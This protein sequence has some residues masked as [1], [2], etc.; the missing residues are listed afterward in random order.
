MTPLHNSSELRTVAGKQRG[1]LPMPT[2]SACVVDSTQS[3]VQNHLSR[4]IGKCR[5]AGTSQRTSVHAK[6]TAYCVLT[7]ECRNIAW[8]IHNGVDSRYASLAVPSYSEPARLF[9]WC[10]RTNR[11]TSLDAVYA[12]R[13]RSVPLANDGETINVAAVRSAAPPA[14]CIAA[15][16]DIDQSIATLG[17]HASCFR[18]D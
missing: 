11:E 8:E 5:Q 16:S 1:P 4:I 3:Q 15:R 14:H 6:T 10:R 12:H 17:L 18:E 7:V 13:G 2:F 9:T